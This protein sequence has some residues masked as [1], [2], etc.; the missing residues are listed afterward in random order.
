MQEKAILLAKEIYNITCKFN[1]I[2]NIGDEEKEIGIYANM[3][4]ERGKLVRSLVDILKNLDPIPEELKTIIEN[5]RQ[6]DRHDNMFF[7][8]IRQ[9]LLHDIKEVKD[10]QKINN[11]YYALNREGESG[12][13]VRQ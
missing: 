8:G 4:E 10:G 2:G 7:E 11:A 6:K 3:I 1:P 5:I 12:F 9:K 13:S